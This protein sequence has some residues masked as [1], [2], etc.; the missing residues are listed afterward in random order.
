MDDTQEIVIAF[1]IKKG[2]DNLNSITE[3]KNYAAQIQH[4]YDN[5]FVTDVEE[6]SLLIPIEFSLSQN[7]L[8]HLIQVQLSVTNYL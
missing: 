5:D 8:I 3:L 7:I 4:W 2:T 1:L 6:N